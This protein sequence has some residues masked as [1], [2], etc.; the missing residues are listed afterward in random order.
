MCVELWWTVTEAAVRLL[1][2]MAALLAV[3]RMAAMEARLIRPPSMNVP[4]TETRESL[5]GKREVVGSIQD[6][7]KE[8]GG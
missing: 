4:A 8:V 5:V 1:V 7:A 2:M 6:G 3:M